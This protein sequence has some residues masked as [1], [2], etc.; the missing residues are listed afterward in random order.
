VADPNNGSLG[1]A[2]QIMHFQDTQIPPPRDWQKFEDLCLDIFRELW[3][4]PTAQKNGRPGQH[5]NGTDI[6]GHCNGQFVGVQCKCKD[7][8]SGSALTE[9]E[10]RE[11]VGNA[12]GFNPPLATWT[13]ATTGKKDANIE[14]IA[15]EITDQNRKQ[16]LF[17]VRVLGWD[18]LKSLMSQSIISHHYPNW[19]PSE[20]R[21][22]TDNGEVTISTRPPHTSRSRET[23]TENELH[24]IAE[25]L[26]AAGSPPT[27]LPLFPRSTALTRRALTE[28][29]K[30]QRTVADPAPAPGQPSTAAQITELLADDK[31]HHLILAAPG[32]GKTHALWHAA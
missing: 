2:S 23:L 31:L 30:L 14:R 21:V 5:Q 8:A 7:V 4:D 18:D 9:G 27:L 12:K 16:N 1:F 20:C 3:G 32:S 22:H 15:R 19:T 13:L 17:E 28:F 29:G 26:L 6:W 24:N 11:E 25:R 10:L